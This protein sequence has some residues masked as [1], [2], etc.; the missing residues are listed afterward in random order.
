[1]DLNDTG[2]ADTLKTLSLTLGYL[3]EDVGVALDFPLGSDGTTPLEAGRDYVA[4]IQPRLEQAVTDLDQLIA[5]Q[6][7]D[8]AAQR[9]QADRASDVTVALLIIAGAFALVAGSAVFALIFLSVTRPLAILQSKVSSVA[10]GERVTGL[11]LSGPAEVTSLAHD[12]DRL[13]EQRRSAQNAL[14]ATDEKYRALFEKSMDAV[15]L[16][17]LEG[18]FIDGNDAML[19]LLGCTREEL[20]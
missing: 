10:S 19:Q 2:A 9:Q 15:Y 18:R 6:Q 16:H 5:G 1:M 8:L 14:K 4:Q 17:D 3:R 7:A 13:A 12:F 20:L 11:S